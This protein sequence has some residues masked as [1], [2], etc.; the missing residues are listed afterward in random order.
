MPMTPEKI[1]GPTF[2][3]ASGGA[4][5]QLIVL[6][7]GYGADGA[8]LIDLAPIMSTVFKDALFISP[9]APH[10]CEVGGFGYQWFS[11]QDRTPDIMLSG[12]KTAAPFVHTLIN[13]LMGEHGL[14]ESQVAIVGFS[15]GTMTGLHV[16]LEREKP[17]A[18]M[19]G[20]SGAMIT[21]EVKNHTPVCLI[22]GDAD[23]VVPYTSMALAKSRLEELGVDVETHTRP[24]LPHSIDDGGLIAAMRFLAKR[25][26]VPMPDQMRLVG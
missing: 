9:N 18:G 3:P 16:A 10:L 11:L 7:H 26:G 17:I 22:H 15:Q 5:K 8:N 13:E 2:G 23:D 1:S 4:P 25:M 12:V 21:K 19:V 14:S 20:F 24:N 6:L